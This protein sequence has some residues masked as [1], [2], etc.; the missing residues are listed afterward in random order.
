MA[1]DIGS[2]LSRIRV[3]AGFLVAGLYFYFA[4]PTPQSLWAGGA[5]AF[6]GILVR[7]WATGH[8]RKNDELTVTGPYAYTRNPLYFGTFVIGLGF[9]M[10]GG[11]T[12]I[13]ILFLTGFATL[14]GSVMQQEMD[15][16]KAKFADEYVRYQVAVPL[17]FPRLGPSRMGRGCFSFQRYVQNKEYQALLGFVAA[18]GLLLLKIQTS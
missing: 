13:L 6:L 14:Y 8:I 17:F 9:S 11:S 15:Y 5:V 10:A 4:Q 2:I 7:A 18:L 3:P 1:L 16:L 12:H